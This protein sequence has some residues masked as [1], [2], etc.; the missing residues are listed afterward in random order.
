MK[1]FR[2]EKREERRE[3]REERREKREKRK[4]AYMAEELNSHPI[5]RRN[6]LRLSG[7]SLGGMLVGGSVLTLAWRGR[8]LSR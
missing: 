6:L 8:Q 5:N 4:G 2:R 3:K 7:Y 1:C